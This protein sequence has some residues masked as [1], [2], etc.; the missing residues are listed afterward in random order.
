MFQKSLEF[1]AQS[2]S[3]QAGTYLNIS[4]IFSATNNYQKALE[5][6][7]AALDT[8]KSLYSSDQGMLSS[9]V[10]A[11]FSTGQEYEHLSR[12]SQAED[13]YRYALELASNI[14]ESPIYEKINENLQKIEKMKKQLIQKPRYASTLRNSDLPTVRPNHSDYMKQYISIDEKKQSTPKTTRNYPPIIDI[15][16][17]KVASA[18]ISSPAKKGGF[19]NLAQI[20]KE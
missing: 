18:R 17:T 12:F 3:H 6:S 8:F 5:Y 9:L 20:K 1:K 14:P 2:S 15:P 19:G 11:A 4:S 10:F 16:Y 7:S 13:I